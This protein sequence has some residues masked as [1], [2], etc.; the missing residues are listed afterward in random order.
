M[1]LILVARARITWWAVS[2]LG[3]VTTS[4][5][6]LWSATISCNGIC[7]TI[8]QFTPYPRSVIL[9]FHPLYFLFVLALKQKVFCRFLSVALDLYL[10]Q[11][12]AVWMALDWK[13]PCFLYYCRK[14]LDSRNNVER[15]LLFLLFLIFGKTILYIYC[16]C[17]EKP[18]QF[19]C[20][21]RWHKSRCQGISKSNLH[22]LIA[23][24]DSLRRRT[25]RDGCWI[26][27][28]QSG[29][30]PITYPYS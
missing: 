2:T 20:I 4:E 25:G 15:K 13:V 22:T 17:S 9:S 21:W 16:I 29:K 23:T 19:G 18:V 14:D 12:E 24:Y 27:H 28:H 6:V 10:E 3:E 1:W 5:R 7:S 11:E 26:R 30:L 8:F